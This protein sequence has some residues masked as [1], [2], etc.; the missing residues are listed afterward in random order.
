MHSNRYVW[1]FLIFA[2]AFLYSQL[3]R[4]LSG[5]P[6]FYETDQLIPLHEAVRMLGGE[7]I[8]K[9]FFEYIFPGAPWL[10][11]QLF[12]IFGVHYRIVAAVVLG[13]GL[14]TALLA[15]RIGQKLRLGTL[16][17]LPAMIYLF[18]GFRWLGLDGS[19]RMISPIL[20]LAAILILLDKRTLLRVALAGALCA[21]SAFFTQQRGFAAVAA[22][23]IFLLLEAAATR[24]AWRQTVYRLLALGTGFAVAVAIF[25]GRFAFAAGLANFYRSTIVY[26]GTFY[27]ADP[28]NNYAAFFGEVPLAAG[29]NLWSGVAVNVFYY[30]TPLVYVWF[31]IF[32][33]QRLRR[34]RRF[35][36]DFWQR[37][38]LVALPGATAAATVF[39]APT[40]LRLF[41]I[42]VPA[43]I[44]LVWLLAQIRFVRATKS[45]FGAA[46]LLL[47]LIAV[48]SGVRQQTYRQTIEVDFA[49]GRL[50]LFP[51]ERFEMYRWVQAHTRPGDAVYESYEPHVYFTS[52]VRNPTSS[53]GIRDNAYTRPEQI[54]RIVA[55]LRA[56]PPKYILWDN[57]WNKPIEQRAPGDNLA[58]L[59]DY[60][61][62]EY[63]PVSQIFTVMN[64]PF[65]V[66]EQKS[67]TKQNN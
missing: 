39:V 14:S 53:V 51:P 12:K 17:F 25:V 4:L 62:S 41:Q 30:A 59:Y 47:V 50:A 6:F 11:V 22:F 38:L 54:A 66:Y 56:D 32:L 46:A 2:A 49:A 40:A 8:Y 48:A 1:I 28:F 10:Y 42:S 57:N 45:V 65:Q 63:R 21:L 5:A 29:E 34:E 52:A 44:L 16:A 55:E 3:F 26:P 31:A 24:V 61:T 36:W 19:H 67:E 23:A 33:V 15:V 18:F 7:I 58:P 20:V 64:R 27:R 35:D 43:L 60:L 9:D 13:I 37:P